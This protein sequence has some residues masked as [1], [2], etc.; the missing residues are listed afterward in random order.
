MKMGGT[1]ASSGTLGN[2]IEDIQYGKRKE[3]LLNYL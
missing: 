2:H 3:M 1:A